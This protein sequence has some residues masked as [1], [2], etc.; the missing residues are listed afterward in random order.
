MIQIPRSLDDSLMHRIAVMYYIENLSQEQISVRVD[1]SRP[2]ISRYLKRARE[3]G[4]VEININEPYDKKLDELAS[5]IKRILGLQEVVIAPL[6]RGRSGVFPE[7]LDSIAARASSF[8]PSLIADSNV[9]GVG[10]GRTLY[11]T[12]LLVD[13]HEQYALHKDKLFVPLI[14]GIGQTAPFYQVNNMVD[15]LAEKF[16][17]RR[18]FFNLP[19]FVN[20]GEIYRQ[21]LSPN[22]LSV[23]EEH[24]AKLDLAIVG[25]GTPR[26]ALTAE[27]E[28]SILEKLRSQGAVGDILGQ[29][30]DV[31]GEICE[32][33]MEENLAG[34]P[35]SRLKK[36]KRVVCLSGGK[37]KVNGIVVAARAGYFNILITDEFTARSI[38]EIT[39]GDCG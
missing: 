14:G 31:E 34:L 2:Q 13:N 30:L 8:L 24:W 35:I 19:A 39:G 18:V 5:G 25:L 22:S 3:V 29:F 7:L 28:T 17:A 38:L 26:G 15:R 9:I 10:W 32:S 20:G 27:I 12:V 1:L 36:V 11:K 37:E 4:M 23:I 6:G 21:D 33:G 16:G